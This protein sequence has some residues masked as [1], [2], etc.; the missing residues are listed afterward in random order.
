MSRLK[1]II[2]KVGSTSAIIVYYAPVIAYV[3]S[4]VL[5]DYMTADIDSSLTK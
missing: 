2:K 3:Y 5:Y 1:N 4:Y